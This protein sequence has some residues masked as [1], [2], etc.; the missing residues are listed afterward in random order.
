MRKAGV[1]RNKGKACMSLSA[2]I[3][4]MV[5]SGCTPE[6]IAAVVKAVEAER[7]QA[8]DD[9]RRKDAERQ[10][11]HRM[12]RD[13]TVTSVMSHDELVTPSPEVFPHTPFPNPNPVNP[14]KKNPKGF[15]KGSPSQAFSEVLRPDVAEAVVEHRQ[16]IRKPLTARAAELLAGKFGA[17][18]DPNAA[19]E[20]MIA[21]GWQGF[22]PEWLERQQPRGQPPPKPKSVAELAW[23]LAKGFDSEQSGEN[24]TKG[25]LALEARSN[26]G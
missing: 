26:S 5:T 23:E 22:E 8:A 3:D 13:V 4:A 7:D 25:P 14:S 1:R 2:I 21:N 12:S 20:T 9:K 16:R 10:R 6:Q 17:C 24:E 18:P 11:R 19:A 15:Q